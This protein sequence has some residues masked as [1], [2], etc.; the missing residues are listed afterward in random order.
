MSLKFSKT[1]ADALNWSEAMLLIRRLANDKNWKMSLLISVGCFTGLR[2]SDL[3]GLRWHQLLSSDE[4]TITEKKTKKSRTIRLN[5]QLKAHVKECYDHI[6][7]TG[8]NAPILVSQKGTVFSVQRINVLLKE[9]KKR[10]NLHI[11]NFSSH[12]LRKTFGRRVVENNQ[13]NVE[14]A[15]LRLAELF[16]HS[17]VAI[18]KRYLGIRQQ[19]LMSVYDSLSF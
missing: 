15:I 5:A 3:L 18:T 11:E 19:E 2:V 14:I 7:P 16:N 17:S 1:T 6:N 4:L 8:L 12:S 13:G 9:I 10:Y